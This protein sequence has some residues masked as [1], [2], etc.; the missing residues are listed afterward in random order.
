MSVTSGFFN[1]INHD[2]LYD[3]EQVSSLFDGLITDGV[4]ENVGEAFKVTPFSESNNTVI[5]GTGRAWFD[6]TWTKNDSQ[7][8]VT[9][10]EPSKLYPRIDAI[11][12]D[13]DRRSSVRKNSIIAVSGGTNGSKPTMIKEE[14]HKQYPIAYV[15]IPAGDPAPITQDNISYNVGMVDCPLVTGIIEILNSEN[16]FLQMRAEFDKWFEGIRDTMDE[17]TVTKI[18]AELDRLDDRIDDVASNGLNPETY[19]FA[20]K[21]NIS[22]TKMLPIISSSGGSPNCYGVDGFILPD[23]YSLIFTAE[24]LYRDLNKENYYQ[25][26]LWNKEGTRVGQTVISQEVS[27]E[28]TAGKTLR[29]G[30]SAVVWYDVDQYPAKVLCAFGEGVAAKNSSS[31]LSKVRTVFR[32]ITVTS[33]HVISSSASY[34]SYHTLSFPS[35][36]PNFPMPVTPAHLSDG[37]TIGSVMF[38]DYNAWHS[39]PD[40]IEAVTGRSVFKISSDGILSG[41]TF[42]SGTSPNGD[43]NSNFA[44]CAFT[45][46]PNNVVVFYMLKGG[47]A[48]RSNYSSLSGSSKYRY[49]V[50]SASSL[51][52]VTSSYP[53][54]SLGTSINSIQAPDSIRMGVLDD[55]DT[56]VECP[57]GL[58]TFSKET[59]FPTSISVAL[60]LSS[61]SPSL[62]GS[63]FNSGFYESNEGLMVL[64]LQSSIESFSA[65]KIASGGLAVWSGGPT[66]TAGIN[67]AST[68]MLVCP[69]RVWKNPDANEVMFLA[70]PTVKLSKNLDF[71]TYMPLTPA[72][73]YSGTYTTNGTAVLIKVTY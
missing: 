17:N 44:Y 62:T 47:D 56:F 5:V 19:E 1:S 11:V 15:T 38:L 18:L 22:V 2:R 60:S 43:Q 25:I 14:L 4:Y 58:Y 6:H 36:S 70:I 40:R 53:Y 32:M 24:Y 34:G 7:F 30:D 21:A 67:G 55:G 49:M 23:G 37:S 48:A 39:T 45:D 50:V 54:N 26:S 13:V 31:A 61:A 16:F 59:S 12:I 35:M 66:A 52:D 57:S 33:D 71:T 46:I 69:H 42:H 72:Q 27:G 8:S 41:E 64:D 65:T 3:A 9:F 51:G 68:T 10:N 73:T 28:I 63:T 29:P 20:K